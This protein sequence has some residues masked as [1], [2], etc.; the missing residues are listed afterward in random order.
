VSARLSV[1]AIVTVIKLKAV[2][3]Y[4]LQVPWMVSHR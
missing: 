3:L 1:F 4:I 2:V